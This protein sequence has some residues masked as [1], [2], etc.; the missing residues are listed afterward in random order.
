MSQSHDQRI[1]FF[2]NIRL[3]LLGRYLD[4]MLGYAR[5][6][7]EITIVDLRQ[8]EELGRLRPDD[9]PPWRGRVD[10]MILAAGY[11]GETEEFLDWVARGR[12][13]AVSI[14][15]DIIHPRLPVV[16]VDPASIAAV[17]ID[18]LLEIGAC[19]YLHLGDARAQGTRLRADAFVADLRRRGR[20][21]ETHEIDGLI[22]GGIEDAQNL[23]N[24]EKLTAL[25][26][27]LPRPVGVL[28][29]NDAVAHTLLLR[30]NLLG[31][32][33]PGDVAIVGVDNT[34]TARHSV[35]S[36]TSVRVPCESVAARGMGILRQLIA[37]ET[38][39]LTGQSVELVAAEEIVPRATTVGDACHDA[40]LARWLSYVEEHGH[41]GLPTSQIA[42]DLGVSR[43]TFERQFHRLVGHSPAEA[44]RQQRLERAKTLLAETVRPISDIAKEVG[45]SESA[46]FSRFF[47]KH[48]GCSPREFRQ[49]AIQR[50][51]ASN[52]A[53][54]ARP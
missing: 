15:G 18:H 24:D 53:T 37:A 50:L 41:R 36:I 4:G 26:S 21:A 48:E 38:L 11:D 33:I 49:R 43:R 31:L 2:G 1:G 44:I 13:P 9:M 3:T 7:G 51:R 19:S 20:P 35:P 6:H 23:A 28:C 47:R 8:T 5:T 30:C 39:T 34:A 27:T 40:S 12:V 42:E 45:F 14:R 16:C 17:A 22:F 52:S 29:S 32:E 54:V 10:G 25:L 46:A